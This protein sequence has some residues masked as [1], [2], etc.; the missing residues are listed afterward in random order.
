MPL[1][2]SGSN[3]AANDTAAEH[4]RLYRQQKR[5]C[6]EENGVLRNLIKRAKADGVN[7]KAMIETVKLTRL[8]PEVVAQDLK[9]Q[10]RYMQI[11]RIPLTAEDLLAGWDAEVSSRQS[12]E[13]DLWDAD[14]KGYRAG[15]NAD[16]IG[17]VPYD[18]AERAQHWTAAWHKG[19]AAIARELGPDV[20]QGDA[21]K[22]RPQRDQPGPGDIAEAPADPPYVPGAAKPA[23]ALKRTPAKRG[24]KAAGSGRSAIH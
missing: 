12:R 2:T 11:I 7:T 8:D 6:E 9:D 17:S 15:R 21:S 19:Q 4:M 10:L 13:D 20:K 5:K 16:D 22:A 1:D 18:D 23:A 14:D 24:R 3:T